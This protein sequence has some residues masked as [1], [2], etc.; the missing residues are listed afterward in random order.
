M[1]AL[2]R[3]ATRFAAAGPVPVFVAV[4]PRFRDRTEELA[5]RPELR[6][7][8]SPRHAS[9]LLVA[10]KVPAECEEGLARVHDQVPGPRAT[11]GWHT[12]QGS[13]AGPGR[14]LAAVRG[15]EVATL[16]GERADPVSQILEVGRQ[17]IRGERPPEPTLLPDEPPWPWRGKGPFGQGG[18]GMMGGRPYGRPM[19]M[20]ADDLR[21]G[22]ALDRLELTLGPFF[23][24]FPPGLTLQVALQGDVIQSVAMVRAPFVQPLPEIF[25]R[26]LR[27][28]VLTGALNAARARLL[29]RRTARV[30]RAAGA[31]ALADRALGLAVAEAPAPAR[32]RRLRTLVRWGGSLAALG[33]SGARSNVDVGVRL[34][35]WLEEAERSLGRAGQTDPEEWTGPAATLRG[36]GPPFDD[37]PDPAGALEG[38]AET[39]PGLEWGEATLVASALPLSPYGEGEE[40]GQ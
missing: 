37:E 24:P 9:I 11:V 35:G 34:E 12:G 3:A 17:L 20:T 31:G 29:L 33:G 40:G 13:G 26:A 38:L 28:P 39:L 21:D 10:G 1:S 32:V 27:E 4:G 6:L 5:L 16:V 19:A 25:R 22:L 30:L 18:E 7:A 8:S 14:W 36:L 2:R 15:L 23:P